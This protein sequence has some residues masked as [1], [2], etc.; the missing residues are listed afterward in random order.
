MLRSSFSV[1]PILYTWA[2]VIN[3]VHGILNNFLM[4]LFSKACIYLPY[5]FFSIQA[6]Q[7]CVATGQ[8]K[9]L[10]NHGLVVIL[11]D[12]FFQTLVSLIITATPTASLDFTSLAQSALLVT[13]LPRYVKES[14]CS[15]LPPSTNIS[16][17][18]SL[19]AIT[20]ERSRPIVM[21]YYRTSDRPS[22]TR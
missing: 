22:V 6:S 5:C 9:A 1:P 7:P 15:S 11:T 14:T 19:F 8:T 3:F 17:V 21:R 12:L 18:Q 10:I 4:H 20:F 16:S 13:L 2:E